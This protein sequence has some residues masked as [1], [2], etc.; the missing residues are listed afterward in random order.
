MISNQGKG[1]IYLIYQTMRADFQTQRR[2][3]MKKT[4][5]GRRTL[6][7]HLRPRVKC[8][9][10]VVDGARRS[11]DRPAAQK[12]VDFSA[13]TFGLQNKSRFHRR[14][15]VEGHKN[16]SCVQFKPLR[17][18]DSHVRGGSKCCRSAFVVGIIVIYGKGRYTASCEGAANYEASLETGKYPQRA[19]LM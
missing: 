7:G 16:S 17:R 4:L 15:F 6:K 8:D 9:L 19:R 3:G 1:I 14:S 18:V 10:D 2:E 13:T 11:L 12:R 5:G